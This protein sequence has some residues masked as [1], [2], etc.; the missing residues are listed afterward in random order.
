MKG[1]TLI[2]VIVSVSIA[3][4]LVGGMIVNYN[5]YND[6]QTLKQTALTLK[7][8]LRFAQAKAQ[9]GEKPAPAC[10]E[11]IGWAVTFVS[12]GYA[13]Q[14]SCNPEGLVGDITSVT[15]P[16][17]VTASPVPAAIIFRV[18]SRG[19]MLV[20]AETITLSGF[21]QT[22]ALEVSPGGDISDLGLQ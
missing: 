3:L 17:G 20:S 5:G 18:L 11:L 8:N 9:S 2:E 6:R 13:T 1:F 19:T 16:S 10:T 4:A 12:G 15:F 21:S 14:A 7:N 22:Y